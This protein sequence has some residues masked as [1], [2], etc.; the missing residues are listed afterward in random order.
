[1]TVNDSERFYPNWR[2]FLE[3]PSRNLTRLA[4]ALES[5]ATFLA[6]ALASVLTGGVL[7][8]FGHTV[9]GWI[10]FVPGA[11]AAC[12]LVWE[13]WLHAKEIRSIMDN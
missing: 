13:V 1:M 3:Y 9:L 7:F 8:F 12:Y 6:M 10:T 5:I 4:A 2:E 11:L